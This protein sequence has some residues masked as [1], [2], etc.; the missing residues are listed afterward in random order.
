MPSNVIASLP[1]EMFERKKG[2]IQRLKQIIKTDICD[3]RLMD[4]YTKG[5]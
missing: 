5:N 1:P 4:K 3:D 2:F